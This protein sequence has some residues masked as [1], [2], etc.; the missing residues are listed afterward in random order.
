MEVLKLIDEIED[1]VEAASGVP[2]TGKVMVD[3][4]EILEIVKEIRIQ[5]P[6]EV[7]QA[8]YIN[9]K[10]QR[11]LAEAQKDADMLMSE[12]E[13]RLKTLVDEDGI[14]REANIKAEEIVTRAQ[15]NAKEIRLGAVE[16]ADSL[17][18]ETQ[19][20]LAEIIDMLT[21]NR[22]ELSGDE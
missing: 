22:N 16:Y 14:T 19:E 10:K 9:D 18:L 7:K 8:A 11:I 1:I 15:N 6:D 21:D 5:L 12:A 13:T 20:A 4:F 2:F 17:L 3:Q